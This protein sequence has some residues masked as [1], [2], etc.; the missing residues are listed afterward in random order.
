MMKVEFETRDKYLFA[1]MTGAYSFE[2]MIGAIERIG[3]ECTRQNC[4]RVLVD[5]SIIGDA[6]LTSRF[7]Y[8]EHAARKLLGLEKCAAFTGKPEQRVEPFTADVAQNRGLSLQVFGNQDDALRW[9]L[10]DL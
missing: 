5:V 2:Q 10:M 3:D 7:K 1:R 8:A 4:K 9:L 6:D